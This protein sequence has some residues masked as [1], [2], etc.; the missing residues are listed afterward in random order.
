[1][2]I[3]YIKQTIAKFI[4]DPPMHAK[5]IVSFTACPPHSSVLSPCWSLY[6]SEGS[7]GKSLPLYSRPSLSKIGL[8]FHVA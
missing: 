6:F 1:M 8:V 3:P 7:K 2:K 5:S 4:N